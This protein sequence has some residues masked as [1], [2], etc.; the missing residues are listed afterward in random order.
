MTIAIVW[1][2]LSRK[3][4]ASVGWYDELVSVLLVWVSYSGATLAVLHGAHLGFDTLADALG[5][6]ARLALLVLREGLFFAFFATLGWAGFEVVRMLRGDTLTSLPW[7][8]VSLTQ[9]I[10]PVASA[11]LI[12]SE[13]LTIPEKWAAE[14]KPKGA[15]HHAEEAERLV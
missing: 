10:I 8:P 6:R 15:K 14:R 4:G 9:A 2:V 1:A 5:L 3:L 7:V 12:I 13:V 11:L